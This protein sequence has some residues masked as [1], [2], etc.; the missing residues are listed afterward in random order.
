MAFLQVD[1][2]RAVALAKELEDAAGKCET[3]R[4]NLAK[5]KANS[6]MY[7]KGDSGNA[8][9]VQ[10]DASEK[11]L[12]ATERKLQRIAGNIRTVADEL[13][14]ADEEIAAKIRASCGGG[15]GSW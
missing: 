2:D 6:E 4:N 8:L 10:A 11:N 15:G 12:R 14:R 9:R 13:R 5:E 3:A 1:Y 7:W